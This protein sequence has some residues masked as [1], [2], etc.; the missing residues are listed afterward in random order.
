MAPSKRPAEGT[1]AEPPKKKRGRPAKSDNVDESRVATE[2]AKELVESNEPI[3]A[4]D[5]DELVGFLH[6]PP[7]ENWTAEEEAEVGRLWDESPEKE[8]WNRMSAKSHPFLLPLFKVCLRV[9]RRNPL[10]LISPLYGLR[11]HHR[12]GD[13]SKHMLYLKAFSQLLT[14]LIVHPCMQRGVVRLVFAIQYT[15]VCRYDDRRLWLTHN[16]DTFSGPDLTRAI[17]AFH[18][19]GGSRPVH[20]IHGEARANIIRAGES[21]TRFSDLLFRIGEIVKDKEYSQDQP[22][23]EFL[24]QHGRNVLPVTT[25]DLDVIRQAIDSMQ[26][27]GDESYK[28]TTEEAFEAYRVIKKK[29]ELPDKHRLK[30]FIER[31][32]KQLLRHYVVDKRSQPEQV[33][34]DNVSRPE[35]VMP[36]IEQESEEQYVEAPVDQA[37]IASDD[38][39]MAIESEP[40]DDGEPPVGPSPRPLPT[41]VAVICQAARRGSPSL[42]DSHLSR[43]ESERDSRRASS[44]ASS[45]SVLPRRPS[46]RSQLQERRED[47]R[48]LRESILTRHPATPRVQTPFPSS[49]QRRQELASPAGH[50]LLS[51]YNFD[52]DDDDAFRP[53]ESPSAAFPPLPEGGSPDGLGLHDRPND[54]M[55]EMDDDSFQRQLNQLDKRLTE[56]GQ[57]V[58]DDRNETQ[59]ALEAHRIETRGDLKVQ[60]LELQTLRGEVE[61]L[62]GLRP[63][64]GTRTGQAE[65]FDSTEAQTTE[66]QATETDTTEGA[67]FRRRL[68]ELQNE[69]TSEKARRKEAEQ[70]AGQ[71]QDEARKATE[72]AREA[73]ERAVQADEKAREADERAR[74]A[75]NESQQLRDENQRLQKEIA[76]AR[77]QSNVR[78]ASRQMS[79]EVNPTQNGRDREPSGSDT[80]RPIINEHEEPTQG[81]VAAE[82]PEQSNLYSLPDVKKKLST[83]TSREPTSSRYPVH[84]RFFK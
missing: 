54:E 20:E 4:S 59:D 56:L 1:D 26:W 76:A 3:D 22:P 73:E 53:A 33:D 83:L 80:S 2:A 48:G 17:Q 29:Q 66:V 81:Q 51:S 9:R 7:D 37:G 50:A 24:T 70:Q 84:K 38:N 65:G 36:S 75:G 11:Y 39:G 52:D 19:C 72:Q 15:V 28:C 58:T 16:V 82:E 31:G 40:L 46:R 78:R 41:R 63:A 27:S 79:S 13:G 61:I 44:T 35:P 5:I 18:S 68:E 64:Q 57:T 30:E 49:F 69:L 67:N 74:Q 45:Q 14:K 34:N 32:Y 42:E 71:S 8:A 62:R 12:H 21:P 10:S 47:A 25:E 23:E 60:Q 77:V 55:A 43:S 6:K